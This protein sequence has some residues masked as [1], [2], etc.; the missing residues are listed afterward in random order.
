MS[1]D[2]L[3]PMPGRP[4]GGGVASSRPDWN[5][6]SSYGFATPSG[7]LRNASMPL[8]PTSPRSP[9]ATDDSE[10]NATSSSLLSPSAAAGGAHPSILSPEGAMNSPSRATPHFAPSLSPNA[11]KFDERTPLVNN[12]TDSPRRASGFSHRS[13]DSRHSRTILNGKSRKGSVSTL[14]SKVRSGA[15]FEP[16]TSTYGQTVSTTSVA[17]DGIRSKTNSPS[18][19]CSCSTLSP[20]WSVSGCCLNRLRSTT[21]VGAWEPSCS[22][23]SPSSPTTPPNNWQRSSEA[24]QVSSRTRTSRGRLS[25]QRGSQSQTSCASSSRLPIQQ[26]LC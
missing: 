5:R 9:H 11:S 16:G 3:T 10:P 12:S 25:E 13:L 4:S 26:L 14:R 18:N 2:L 23:T 17:H 24:T 7:S 15:G 20:S 21:P 1:D 19:V 8:R 22:S 6:Q